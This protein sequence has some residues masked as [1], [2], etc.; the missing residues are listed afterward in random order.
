M[1][2]DV[3]VDCRDENGVCFLLMFFDVVLLGFM[4]L[5]E[6]DLVNKFVKYFGAKSAVTSFFAYRA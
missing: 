2:Y 3:S 1:L 5:L 4:W 6:G